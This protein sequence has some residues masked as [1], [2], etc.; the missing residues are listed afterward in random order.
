MR[1]KFQR[2]SA[3]KCLQVHCGMW[4]RKHDKRF[5]KNKMS[6]KYNDRILGYYIH[7]PY[8]KDSFNSMNPEFK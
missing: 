8:V 6:V 4:D 2:T 5:F 3:N 1:V 7:T